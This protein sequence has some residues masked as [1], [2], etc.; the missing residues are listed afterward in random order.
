M[1]DFSIDL[2][3]DRKNQIRCEGRRKP[4]ITH[5]ATATNKSTAAGG[6]K[7]R[8]RKLVTTEETSAGLL[9]SACAAR[10]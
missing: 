3:R 5:A 4:A 10:S 2:A 6:P 8:K 1:V 7:A 9:P